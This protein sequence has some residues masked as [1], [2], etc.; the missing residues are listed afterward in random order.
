MHNNPLHIF[1]N[2][3]S[4]HKIHIER[5]NV[6]LDTILSFQIF[7]ICLIFLMFHLLIHH[8]LLKF[9]YQHLAVLP[10]SEVALPNIFDHC[11]LPLIP[12]LFS[13]LIK[14]SF[15]HS[16]THLCIDLKILYTYHLMIYIDYVSYFLLHLFDLLIF[17]LQNTS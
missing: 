6:Y 4:N 2:V 7:P 5:L 3:P 16:P 11:K 12:L 17:F 15:Y 8:L 14:T 10:N 13:F 9:E 1:L